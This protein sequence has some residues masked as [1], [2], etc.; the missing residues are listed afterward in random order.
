MDEDIIEVDEL[1]GD[2]NILADASMDVALDSTNLQH[3]Q[4]IQ[5]PAKG[6]AE[7]LDQLGSSGCCQ[8][9]SWSRHGAIAYITKTGCGIKMRCLRYSPKGRRWALSEEFNISEDSENASQLKFVH[10]EWNYIGGDL[11]AIDE[12]GRISIFTMA[13]HAINQITQSRSA[14]SDAENELD[15]PVGFYWLH[16]DRR[17]SRL[18][19]VWKTRFDISFTV[20][21]GSSIFQG[22]PS[23]DPSSYRP[24]A[25]RTILASGAGRSQ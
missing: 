23:L 15:Q 7:R 4:P 14:S 25:T 3:L 6:L 16:Q 22:E 11:A 13:F 10:L 2:P 17:V 12:M 19:G 1:F 21:D 8:K 20:Y 24:Q 5:A 9:V 18:F